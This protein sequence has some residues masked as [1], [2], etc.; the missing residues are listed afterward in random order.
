MDKEQ[1]RQGIA[2]A[3]GRSY[4]LRDY[5]AAQVLTNPFPYERLTPEQLAK[6]AYQIADAMLKERGFDKG[7]ETNSELR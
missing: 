5:F 3:C 6:E 1:Q 4:P 2:L 7:T